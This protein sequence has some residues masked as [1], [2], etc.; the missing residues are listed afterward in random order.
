MRDEA[1]SDVL[2]IWLYAAAF[3]L[4]GAWIS[5]LLYNAGKALAEVA[6]AKQTNGPLDWLAGHCRTMDF[7]AFFEVSVIL[8]AGLL[9]FPLVGWLRGGRS[10]ERAKVGSLRLP[11]GARLVASGQRLWKNPRGPMQAVSG[12]LAVSAL[13]LVIAG[14]LVMAGLFEWKSP[15]EPMVGIVL[16]VVTMAVVMAVVQEFLFRGIALGIFLRAMRPAWALGLSAVLFALVHFLNP[17]PGLRV[18]DPDAAGVGFDLLRKI[19]AQFFEL[20]VV[21][22]TFVPLVGLGMMLAYA[23]WETSSLWLSTGIHAGWIFVNGILAYLTWPVG[24]PDS[25]TWLLSG[26]TL[27]EGLAPLAGILMAGGLV[28]RLTTTPHAPEDPA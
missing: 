27:R 22:G 26:S 13:F 3:V 21:L 10:S 2:K 25:L 18:V 8:S 4:L 11:E 23:R 16:R 17:S 15:G 5:P 20:R 12:F 1:L 7:P 9:F 19:A 24:Q 6:A 14:M 28:I